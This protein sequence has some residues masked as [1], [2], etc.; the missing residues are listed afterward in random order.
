MVAKG[1]PVVSLAA[2]AVASLQELGVKAGGSAWKLQCA[3]AR[4]NQDPK[5]PD[6][7]KLL[8]ETGCERTF[9]PNGVGRWIH[10][11]CPTGTL[12]FTPFSKAAKDGDTDKVEAILAKAKEIA[13]S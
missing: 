2:Q 4:Y 10:T 13:A 3:F 12:F 11:N 5:S 7:G 1:K 8:P 6:Y 9:D